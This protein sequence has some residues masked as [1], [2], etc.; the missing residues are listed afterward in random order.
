MSDYFLQK[1]YCSCLIFYIL[2][3]CE[4]NENKI[5]LDNPINFKKKI[6]NITLKE[7]YA[8]LTNI[9]PPKSNFDGVIFN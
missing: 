7:L 3:D 4:R 6:N 1:L 5:Q 8:V 9:C 2:E